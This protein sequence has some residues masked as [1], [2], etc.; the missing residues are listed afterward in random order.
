M[1]IERDAHDLNDQYIH[2]HLSNGFCITAAAVPV[3][4]LLDVLLYPKKDKK[5][6]RVQVTSGLGGPTD[7]SLSFSY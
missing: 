4:L 1:N 2:I 5:R 6:N 7:L 3:G